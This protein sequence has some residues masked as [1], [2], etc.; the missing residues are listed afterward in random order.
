MYGCCITIR[1]RKG[2]QDGDE[3]ESKNRGGGN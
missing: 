3:G 2:G 1:E